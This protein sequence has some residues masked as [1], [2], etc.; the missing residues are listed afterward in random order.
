MCLGCV[1]N[2]TQVWDE[3]RPLFGNLYSTP[4]FSPLAARF[5]KARGSESGKGNEAQAGREGE[6]RRE[7]EWERE[8]EWE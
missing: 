5:L 2:R 1:R 3:R 8:K 6:S 7:W 4:F